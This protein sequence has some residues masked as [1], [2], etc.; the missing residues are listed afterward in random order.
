MRQWWMEMV[1]LRRGSASLSS[2]IRLVRVRGSTICRVGRP[3]TGAWQKSRVTALWRR[4]VIRQGV[5]MLRECR[6]LQLPLVHQALSRRKRCTLGCQQTRKNAPENDP[7]D[8]ATDRGGDNYNYNGR[9]RDVFR[10]CIAREMTKGAVGG[11]R[12]SSKVRGTAQLHHD[13]LAGLSDR[14]VLPH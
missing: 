3:F 9:I 5:L 12:G 7:E 2:F 6:E 4:G 10:R 11:V 1:S 8:E 13:C 14:M